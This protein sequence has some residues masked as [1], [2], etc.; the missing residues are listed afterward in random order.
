MNLR[1]GFSAIGQGG[2]TNQFISLLQSKSR[3]LMTG[4]ITFKY[5]V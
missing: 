2:I 3:A 4:V 1:V 5:S